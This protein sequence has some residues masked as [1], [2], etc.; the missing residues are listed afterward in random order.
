MLYTRFK[1]SLNTNISVLEFYKYIRNIG[2]ISMDILKKK[3]R[4]GENYSKFTRKLEKTPKN[5]KISKNIYIYI[6]IKVIL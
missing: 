3:N 4:C 2:E 1:I 6:Y 5:D